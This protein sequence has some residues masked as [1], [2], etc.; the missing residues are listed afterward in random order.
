MTDA[1]DRYRAYGEALQRNPDDAENLVN[2]F[3][4]LSEDG[5]LANGSLYLFLA[6]RA[7]L[8]SPNSISQAFNYGSAL[9][10]SGEFEEALK[11]FLRCEN[12]APR[13][14][15][16]KVWHHIGIANR[17]LG[18]NEAAIEWY[19]R[20]L[21]LK[22]N[23][24]IRKDRAIALLASGKLYEGLKAFECRRQLAEERLKA[25]GG[26]LVA[27]QKLPAGVVHWQG[28]DLAGKS[29]VVYHEEGSGDFIQFC[30]F[31]PK[32]R[33]RKPSKILLTGPI[34]N[35]LD[36]VSDQIEVDG[37]VPLEGPFNSDYVIGSM[38]LPWQLRIDYKD[39]SG[40]PYMRAGS[41][42]IPSRGL[43]DVGLVWR[44]NPEYG[45]DTHRSMSFAEFCPLFDL[46]DVAFNSL[47]V[48]GAQNE[49]MKL[50][51][52]GFVADY[53]SRCK[54]WRDT[55][56]VISA[57]DAVVTVDTAVAHLAGA[58]GKPVF[59]LITRASDWRWNR[60]SE[61]TAWYDSATVIRQ[62]RQGDWKPCILRVREKLEALLAERRREA[63]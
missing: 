55:A 12:I 40:K 27:Q 2:Q 43:L 13:D 29:I 37:I 7:Y 20:S 34:P 45:M 48:G 8:N 36:L 47:Q 52:A 32:L 10:R 31:I 61:K 60:N 54:T 35:L 30:R 42:S 38:S 56:K 26:K 50:G 9:Q 59:I 15:K 24:A 44:G 49:I 57:L 53:G 4:L 62:N 14:W 19:D 21:S 25:N 22:S 51:F 17:A 11:I 16:A 18:N 3:S 41:A 46:K 1:V 6:R 23:A 33:E 39:V 5:D 63:A 28:E 58:M